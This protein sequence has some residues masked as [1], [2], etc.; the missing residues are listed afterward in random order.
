MKKTNEVSKLT[1]VSRRTL[2]YYDDEGLLAAERSA[3]NYRLYDQQALEKIWEILV[4]K[5]MNFELREI[6][7]L[8]GLPE[9]QKQR[10]LEKQMKTLENQIIDLKVQIGFISFVKVRGM[11]PLPAE[12][13][14]KTYLNCIAELR[15]EMRSELTGGKGK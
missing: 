13:C 5:E 4:Y 6:R 3:N 12:G 14:G 10:Y 15:E 1:G 9:S 8:F 7:Y 11:P 2:Q